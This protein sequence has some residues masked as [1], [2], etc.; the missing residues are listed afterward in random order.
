MRRNKLKLSVG[1]PDYSSFAA[2]PPPFIE[3]IAP[4]PGPFTIQPGQHGTLTLE[5]R[6]VSVLI[7]ASQ[8]TLTWTAPNGSLASLY[9]NANISVQQLN[10]SVL[11]SRLTLSD[12]QHSES[13]LFTCTISNECGADSQS[14]LV[15]FQGTNESFLWQC[16]WMYM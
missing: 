3:N 2:A 1:F 14:V 8:A 5:C 11:L 4:G 7:D 15:L 13:G 10:E 9:P 16:K 6:G 12:G